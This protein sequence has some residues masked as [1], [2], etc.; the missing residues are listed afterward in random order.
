MSK[1]ACKQLEHWIESVWMEDH[2][3][4]SAVYWAAGPEMVESYNTDLAEILVHVSLYMETSSAA[5]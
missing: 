2:D 1:E 3:E 4:A 5:E